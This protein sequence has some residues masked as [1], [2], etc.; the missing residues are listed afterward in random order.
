MRGRAVVA[1]VILLLPGRHTAA[2]LIEKDRMLESVAFPASQTH[3]GQPRAVFG[4]EM[5]LALWTLGGSAPLNS[6]DLQYS[7]TE[8]EGAT[9]TSRGLVGS[10]IDQLG[11]YAV[12][13]GS[14]SFALLVAPA[15]MGQQL[16]WRLI[17]RTLQSLGPGAAWSPQR[18]AVTGWAFTYTQ[19]SLA[20]DVGRSAHHLV[21]TA[22][23]GPPDRT[24]SVGSRIGYV[25]SLD[26]GVTWTAPV[27]LSGQGCDRPQV[28]VGP[29]GE[30]HVLWVDAMASVV[31]G[32]RSLDGGLMFGA[33]YVVAP[34][35]DNL[36]LGP[37]DFLP[38]T[39]EYDYSVPY[40]SNVRFP[41]LLRVAV[42]A[43]AGPH[44]GRLHAA[45]TDHADGVRGPFSGTTVGEIEPNESY[46]QAT[47]FAIGDEIA[48]SVFSGPHSSDGDAWTFEGEA[49]RSVEITGAATVGPL[50]DTPYLNAEVLF[51][52]SPG[53]VVSR[54]GYAVFADPSVPVRPVIL[55]LPRTGRYFIRVGSLAQGSQ[56]YYFEVR[57]WTPLPGSAAR[58]QRDVVAVHSDDGGA[59][60]SAKRRVNDGPA[61]LDESHPEL[62]VDAQGRVHVMW[63]DRR[64]DAGCGAWGHQYWTHSQDGGASFRPAQRLSSAPTHWFSRTTPFYFPGES[65]ALVVSGGFVHA[66]WVDHRMPGTVFG[67]Q[68]DLYTTRVRLDGLVSAVVSRFEAEAAPGGVRVRW[69]L[70]EPASATRVRLLRRDAEGEAMI[71]ETGPEREGEAL[72]TEAVAPGIHAY[73]LEVR[74]TDG[75]THIEGPIEVRVDAQA[76]GLAWAAGMPNPVRRG[77]AL[78]LHVPRSGAADVALFDVLGARV[79]TLHSGE[80]AAGAHAWTWPS[81]P[82]SMAPG[83]YLL[84]ARVGS[85]AARRRIVLI[86]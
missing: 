36:N 70:G 64:D 35:L 39:F 62:T 34:M 86:R 45:W 27:D 71:A 73:V 48:G 44:H 32:R 37:Y 3:E 83:V 41:N 79:A 8:D 84:H 47:P 10:S 74:H 12:S 17:A 21:F 54:L 76:A 28:V 56:P 63:M 33:P 19:P 20:W 51:C 26:D 52:E 61:R 40:P 85:E 31:R 13:E 53:G 9:W 46:E 50:I 14:G 69:R 78:T 67:D 43:S 6:R 11:E 59:T 55:T 57:D 80:L 2:Q 22:K 5:G 49:G 77:G 30:V 16:P 38:T 58:D 24:V 7:T 1:A 75:R 23:D 60:W 72:D 81:S 25:R 4:G 66:F 68:A 15:L 65:N 82:A 42:D 18:T 29:A